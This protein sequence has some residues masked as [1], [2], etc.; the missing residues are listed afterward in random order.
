M[1]LDPYGNTSPAQPMQT[2]SYEGLADL[3]L[4]TSMAGS[5]LDVLGNF[6]A[7]KSQKAQLQSQAS[8]LE[9]QQSMSAINARDAE[10]DAQA[11]LEAGQREQGR[12][13]QEYGQAKAAVRAST[14]GRGIQ[15]GV[16]S[17]AEVQAS[18][19]LAK[20]TDVYAVNSNAVRAANAA[21]TRAVNERNEGLLAGVSAQNLRGTAGSLDPYAAA[22]GSLLRNASG[23]SRQW[24]ARERYRNKKARF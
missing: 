12:V 18:I 1:A 6:Y 15:Q 14:G 20:Q 16:G 9:F 22:G 2:G 17:A 3:G 5:A 11:I 19:E 4:W 23:I 8:S 10:M 7:V 13:S 24:L 21:R